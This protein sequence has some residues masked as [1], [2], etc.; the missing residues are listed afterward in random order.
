MLGQVADAFRACLAELSLIHASSAEAS[1]LRGRGPLHK[2]GNV[3][4]SYRQTL[5]IHARTACRR[6]PNLL[7]IPILGLLNVLSRCLN[8]LHTAILSCAGRPPA[9]V[10]RSP[11]GPTALR[12]PQRHF[13][14]MGP[15]QPGPRAP[16]L[17]LST[18]QWPRSTRCRR[19]CKLSARRLSP[20]RALAL[21]PAR[22]LAL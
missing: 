16:P 20:W 1:F 21:I 19:T 7:P 5:C 9:L 8:M 18:L 2:Q 15:C 3:C 4:L 13:P 10:A 14:R 22:A 6:A 17:A 12:C 11:R